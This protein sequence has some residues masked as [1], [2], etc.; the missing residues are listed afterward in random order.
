LFADDS[1]LFFK[2]DPQQANIIKEV[3]S[4]YTR[5]TGQLINPYKCSILFGTGCPQDARTEVRGVLQLQ[6]EAFE[7]KYLGL[8]TPEGRMKHDQFQPLSAHFGKRMAYWSDKNLSQAAKE[9][10]IKSVAQALPTYSMGVFKLPTTLCEDYMRLIRKYW[11]GAS[12]GR[13]RVQ[14][15]SWEEMIMPKGIG[16][17]GFRDLKLF[18]QALLARQA[19][20]LIYYADSLCARLLKAKY[21]RQGKLTD[22]AFP[23]NATPTWKAIEYRLELLKKG[24]IWRVANGQSIRIWRDNWIPREYSLKPIT[25]RRRRRSR[26]RWVSNF[27]EC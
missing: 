24:A 19:W 8:P 3:L 5:S 1:L 12:N 4:D 16:G 11:W 26:V 25:R 15:C 21:Y 22:T 14:W 23:S 18:N 7:T 2:G 20:R 13:S 17:M 10:Q 27:E 6:E 9:V